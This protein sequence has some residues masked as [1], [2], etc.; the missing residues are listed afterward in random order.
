MEYLM[1][2]TAFLRGINISGKNKIAMAELK[3]QLESLGF[4]NVSTYLNSGNVLLKTILSSDMLC[5]CRK[6]DN[7]NGCNG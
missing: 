5:Y 2:Y 3:V 4:T 7:Q 6:A 1:N